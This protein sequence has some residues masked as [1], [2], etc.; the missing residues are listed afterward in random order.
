MSIDGPSFI[1]GLGVATNVCGWIYWI[2]VARMRRQD[3]TWR[4]EQRRRID[5]MAER[6]NRLYD[7]SRKDLGLPP[8]SVS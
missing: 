1:A 5:E 4:D 3:I 2:T 7:Q 6:A 8:R